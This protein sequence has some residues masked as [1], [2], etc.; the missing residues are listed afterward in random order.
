[1][2]LIRCVACKSLLQDRF[3]E[4]AAFG[5]AGSELRF[6]S[7]AK[8]QQFVHFGDDALLFS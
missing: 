3:E 5:L 1:M 8:G 4:M 7:V 2:S 6:E